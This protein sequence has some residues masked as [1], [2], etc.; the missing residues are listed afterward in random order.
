MRKLRVIDPKMFA[1]TVEKLDGV[2][3][4]SRKRISLLAKTPARPG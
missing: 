4:S 1:V 2:V 3:V